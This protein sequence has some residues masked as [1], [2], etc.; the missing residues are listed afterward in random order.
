VD[1]A[2]ELLTNSG[3][4]SCYIEFGKAKVG[5]V[6]VDFFS[7]PSPKGTHINAS[8]ALV[9]E[10]EYFGSSRKARWAGN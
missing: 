2:E 10:K 3:A 6:A 4:G 8:E 7:G 5:H 1:K 9:A